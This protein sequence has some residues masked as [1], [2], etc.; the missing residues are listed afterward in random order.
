LYISQ[1]AVFP[2]TGTETAGVAAAVDSDFASPVG[3]G[4]SQ[5]ARRSVTRRILDIQ[6]LLRIGIHLGFVTA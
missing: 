4:V 5:A 1:K 2:E 3:F 6:R